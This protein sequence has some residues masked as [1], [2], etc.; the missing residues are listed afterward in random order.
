MRPAI[1][2]TENG[3][4]VNSCAVRKYRVS[5]KQAPA[6]F[7]NFVGRQLG[8]RKKSK[9]YVRNDYP[10][11]GQADVLTEAILARF[12]RKTVSKYRIFVH[13]MT[14]FI[15]DTFVFWDP[16]NANGEMGNMAVSVSEVN[17]TFGIPKE[18]NRL[19]RK[20]LTT[21]AILKLGWKDIHVQISN[22]RS[23]VNAGETRTRK[24]KYIFGVQFKDEFRLSKRILV[25]PERPMG[26]IVLSSNNKENA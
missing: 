12:S 20:V 26:A 16:R 9:K 3:P 17:E 18:H 6:V 15:P 11:V 2:V 14:P 7:Q 1:V 10:G 19:A 8:S 23:S 24:E 25:K 5:S 21:Y 4:R 13:S 22:P